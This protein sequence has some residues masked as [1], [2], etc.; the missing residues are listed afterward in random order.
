MLKRLKETD[1][2][3]YVLMALSA[4]VALGIL[5]WVQQTNEQVEADKLTVPDVRWMTIVEAEEVLSKAGF[6]KFEFTAQGT[7]DFLG[8][9]SGWYTRKPATWVIVKQVPAPGEKASVSG[10]N[11][12]FFA[13]QEGSTGLDRAKIAEG[14]E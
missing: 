12:H 10:S 1:W 3:D 5:F 8:A 14:K 9:E 7:G 6:Q 13:Y 4:V 11:L 2:A